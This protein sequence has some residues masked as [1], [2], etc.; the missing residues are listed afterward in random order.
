MEINDYIHDVCRELNINVYKNR[1]KT[2]LTILKMRYN[3]TII[4]AIFP[5]PP[6]KKNAFH[7]TPED[8]SCCCCCWV[9]GLQFEELHFGNARADLNAARV[10]CVYGFFFA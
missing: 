7:Q 10:L 2:T 3:L 8:P 9:L 5:Q 1:S 6:N 4:F